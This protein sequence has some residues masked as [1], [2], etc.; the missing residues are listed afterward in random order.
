MQSVLAMATILF[1]SVLLSDGQVATLVK[2][3]IT[4][5]EITEQLKQDIAEFY[6]RFRQKY[7]TLRRKHVKELK[8]L[9]RLSSNNGSTGKQF[10]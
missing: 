9:R 1:N 3:R 4:R 6:A 5:Q 10:S 7:L 2:P 8:E